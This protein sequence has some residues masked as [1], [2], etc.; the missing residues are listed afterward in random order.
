MVKA[1]SAREAAKFYF[2]EWNIDDA[3]QVGHAWWIHMVRSACGLHMEQHLQ[4][5]ELAPGEW[6]VLVSHVPEPQRIIS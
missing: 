5:S 6:Q 2:E 1:T 3:M 4:V